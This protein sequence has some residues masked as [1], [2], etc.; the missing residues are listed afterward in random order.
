MSRYTDIHLEDK[1]TDILILHVGVNDLLNGNSQSSVENLVLNIHKIIEKCKRAGVRNIFVSSLVYTTRVSLPTLERV[2]ILISNYCHKDACFYI[3]NRNIRGFCL[4][5]DS[6][7]LLESG[8]KIL[9]NNSIVSLNKCFLEQ[10]TPSSTNIFLSD[11]DLRRTSSLTT[12]LQILHHEKLIHNK[13]PMI[14]YLNINSLQN[15]LTDLRVILKYLS[16][17][18]FVLSETKLDE[19]F[20]KAQFT[21]DGYKIRARRDRNKFRGGLIEYV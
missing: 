13:N 17:D 6:L 16:L 10:H 5:K 8:K 21:L 11:S 9:A 12:K 15:K 7:H 18:Y 2:H 1:S 4:Q 14:G 20:P 3:D 19:S